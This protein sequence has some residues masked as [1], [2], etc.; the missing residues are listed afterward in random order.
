MSFWKTSLYLSQPTASVHR[1]HRM[2]T[3]SLLSRGRMA[4]LALHQPDVLISPILF[5]SLV[6]LIAPHWD[7]LQSDLH[8]LYL[9]SF[10]CCGAGRVE[11]T[12]STEGSKNSHRCNCWISIY[13]LL[14][15]SFFFLF[16]FLHSEIHER[17]NPLCEE[18]LSCFR[19]WV[20]DASPRISP[21]GLCLCWPAVAAFALHPQRQ[22]DDTPQDVLRD[23]Q[24]DSVR[25]RKQVSEGFTQGWDFAFVLNGHQPFQHWDLVPSCEGAEAPQLLGCAGEIL[26]CSDPM[27]SLE[28]ELQVFVFILMKCLL[29]KEKTLY[30]LIGYIFRAGLI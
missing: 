11:I 25:P 18:R 20:G 23:T 27:F 1:S 7:G 6:L 29:L 17:S 13:L 8:L 2:K 5:F 24:H 19:N 9:H 12:N 15:F 10:Q 14:P 22:E 3:H 4:L 28:T 30:T 21:L 16:F 26:Q